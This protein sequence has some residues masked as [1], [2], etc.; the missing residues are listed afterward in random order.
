MAQPI[1]GMKT[2]GANHN[3]TRGTIDKADIKREHSELKS[4]SDRTVRID[5]TNKTI[6][7]GDKLEDGGKVIGFFESDVKGE[8][9]VAIE[10]CQT[11]S[12]RTSQG[13]QGA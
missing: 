7:V 9:Y 8:K 2:H 5:G 4:L 10:R 11:F 1:N 13:D 12:Y 3:E 6:T